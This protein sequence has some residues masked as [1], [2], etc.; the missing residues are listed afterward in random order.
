LRHAR[1]IFPFIV[2]RHDDERFVHAKC[3]LLRRI[4]RENK[5]TIQ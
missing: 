2:S 3:R 5:R 1:E 4:D